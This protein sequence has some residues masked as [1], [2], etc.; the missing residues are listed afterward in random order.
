VEVEA[1]SRFVWAHSVKMCYAIVIL[2]GPNHYR[3]EDPVIY[4]GP[5]SQ[6]EK[7]SVGMGKWM[8]GPGYAPVS[9]QHFVSRMSSGRIDSTEPVLG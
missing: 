9:Q 5:V 1:C 6:Q 7:Q 3:L 8:N 4:E 2:D